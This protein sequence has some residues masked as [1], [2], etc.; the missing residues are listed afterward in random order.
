MQS[1]TREDKA[2]TIQ[3][4]AAGLWA[5]ECYKHTANQYVANGKVTIRDSMKSLYRNYDAPYNTYF[6]EA[7]V[8]PLFEMYKLQA[9][10]GNCKMPM[11]SET[12]I[13]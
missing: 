3:L 1:F 10:L 2:T 9:A 8:E 4:Q 7:D 11:V 13:R 5:Y 6:Q 12:V